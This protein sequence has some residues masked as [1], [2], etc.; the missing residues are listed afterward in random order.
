MLLKEIFLVKPWAAY[1]TENIWRV[2]VF[3]PYSFPFLSLTP[4]TSEKLVSKRPVFLIALNYRD[5]ASP[6][7]FSRLDH[8]CQLVKQV[9]LIG[10]CDR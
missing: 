2:C 5:V 9:F 10:I 1:Y 4:H 6:S 7:F 3:S 8:G